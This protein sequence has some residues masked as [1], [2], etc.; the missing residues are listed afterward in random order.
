MII[1]T[2]GNR[3]A[4]KIFVKLFGFRLESLANICHLQ[5]RLDVYLSTIDERML[6]HVINC[7][8]R[9]I[10][11]KFSAK[12]YQRT[13]ICLWT[14]TQSLTRNSVAVSRTMIDSVYFDL[15]LLSMTKLNV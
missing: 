5:T 3:P 12:L 2:V 4:C 11:V 9:M 6:G 14:N 10:V 15:S 8:P 7:P 1:I 13:L